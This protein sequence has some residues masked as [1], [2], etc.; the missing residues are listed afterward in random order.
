MVIGESSRFPELGKA[1]YDSGP[2]RAM[3]AIAAALERLSRRGFLAIDDP[4]LAAEQFNWLVMGG[5]V[6][7]AMFLGDDATPN[8]AALRRHAVEAVRVFLDAYAPSG[9]RPPPN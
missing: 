6:N 3:K 1:L 2:G 5:P 8:A 7:A 4:A 9:P